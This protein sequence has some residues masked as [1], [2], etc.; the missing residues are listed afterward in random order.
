VIPVYVITGFLDA[1]KT[2]LLNQLLGGGKPNVQRL[3]L[4]F[5]SGEEPLR[6]QD[7][8]CETL[9]FPKKMLEREPRQITEDIYGCLL[10]NKPQE[11]WIEWNCVAP[12]SQLRELLSR[13][14][15]YRCCRVTKVIHIADAETLEGIL[16]KTGGALPDQIADCDFAA[17]RNASSDGAY[18]RIKRVLRAL[19]PGIPVYRA[20][21]TEEIRGRLYRK[22][23]RPA[24]VFCAA[25]AA[26]TAVY[27]CTAPLFKLPQTLVNTVINVFLGTLL[28]AVPF[29]IIGVLI[30]SAIQVFVPR[31]AIERLFPK[32]L[33]LGMLAAVLGGFCLPVCDCA[34]IPVFRSLVKKGVPLPAAIT[35]MTAAP[36]INPVVMLSTY[37]AFNGS[38]KIVAA[39][40]G[41]GIFA[42][43]LTGLWFAL[44][45]SRGAVLA[46]GFD[47]AMCACG[48]Y[49]ADADGSTWRGKTA[50]FL[51]HSQAEFFNVGKYLTVG[52]FAAALFQS[53]MTTA[54]LRGGTAIA[55][56]LLV[57]MAAA[58]VLSLCSSSDAVIARGFASRFP[59]GAV[60]GFLVF[61]PMMDVKNV[62]MLSG[63]FSKRFVGR[64]LCVVFTVCFLTALVFARYVTN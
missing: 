13:R 26:L 25:L 42:S 10:K 12:L 64:L 17:A 51:R 38:V 62:I 53:V 19:N 40:V 45:P 11:I 46:G 8:G 6:C 14:S 24:A 4:Q 21:Q 60:M 33:G 3:V 50:L 57:M 29:L 27:L 15:L 18:R 58:F 61:G 54:P 49:E 5:E 41:M 23:P 55:A 28:Q 16:G 30:S 22:K 36:V 20:E 7:G 47:G 1:G 9:S 56:S 43:V 32:K 63:G 35:F 31:E 52:A 44:R 2:T 34:S 37:Y 59:L 48:C 39:R